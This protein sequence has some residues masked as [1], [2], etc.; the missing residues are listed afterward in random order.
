MLPVA[1]DVMGGDF[2]PEAI[3]KGALE[4]AEEG[5]PVVLVGPEEILKSVD[6]QNV[7]TVYASEVIAMDEDPA[8][9][10]RQK[11]DSSIVRGLEL[12][13]DNK[14][15][16]FVSAGN[17]GA[18]MAASVFRLGRIK[19]V[20]RPGIATPLPIPN[21]TPAVLIDAGANT[22]C[23]PEWLAQFAQMASI[24]AKERFNIA[25]PKVALLSNGEEANKGSALVKETY[26][27]LKNEN[28]SLFEFIG[29]YEG[30]DLLTGEADVIVTD[31]FT[32]NVA[33]KALEGSSKFF[34]DTL[35]NVIGS[36]ESLKD[37]AEKL[38]S[39]LAP[40]ALQMDPETT[41]GAMLL[42]VKGVSVISHGSSSFRAI[43]NAIKAASQ[44]AEAQ[45]IS[46]IESI[47]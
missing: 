32:G 7:S 25:L 43:K 5:I 24:F 14:A 47:I 11:K 18:V 22:E 6:K 44:M 16:S 2:A 28:S 36:D 1:V 38:F 12:V 20:T 19:R 39:R 4:T 8:V 17:T 10:V 42:G 41:G 23:R 46:K 45:L 13:R 9:A 29:N 34:I 35:V 31:G 33:L 21:R 37:C 3:L 30:R 27:L 15:S 26:A 40:I